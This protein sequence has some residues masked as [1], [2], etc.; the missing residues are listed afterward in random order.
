[1]N[2]EEKIIRENAD[3]A[4]SFA[5]LASVQKRQDIT[6]RDDLFDF[7]LLLDAVKLC[8]R[9][10]IPVRI[11]DSGSRDVGQLEWLA[12]EGAMVYTSD[13][14]QR[15][16]EGLLGINKASKQGK[17]FL[18]YL[19]N[20]P[21]TPETQSAE[22]DWETLM[23]L[24]IEGVYVFMSHRENKRD[25][26]QLTS[27]ADDCRRGGSWLV[28]YHHGDLDS[29]LLELAR[30]GAWI[31]VRDRCLKEVDE[32]RL[33]LDLICTARSAGGNCVLHLERALAYYSLKDILDTGSIVLF[34]SALIDYRS[35]L[36]PLQ[37]RASQMKIDARAYYLYG[38]FFF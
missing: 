30:S 21:L 36:K 37:M 23:A 16:P 17:S 31:H 34:K 38:S 15:D 35:P 26:T 18:A 22:S 14:A 12:S 13:D 11:V 29:E 20:G 24:G 25:V 9:K 27:L 5:F 6:V 1:M 3:A 10:G 7:Q 8:R 28:C 4:K 32:H 2:H 33:F 19:H